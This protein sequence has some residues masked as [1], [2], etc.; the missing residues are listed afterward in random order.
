MFL[1]TLRNVQESIRLIPDVVVVFIEA[2]VSLTWIV[3]FLEAPELENKGTSQKCDG[4]E[5]GQSIFIMTT[6]ISWE[7]NSANATVRVINLV[8]KPGE[9]VAICGVVGSGKSTLLAAIHGEVP[10][11]KG[12]VS[13]HFIPHHGIVYFTFFKRLR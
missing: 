8:V 11:I 9:K 10:N 13:N 12:I 3:K 6:E 7:T 4:K 2:K 1:A 5:L